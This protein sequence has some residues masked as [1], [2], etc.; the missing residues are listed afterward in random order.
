MYV[1]EN[2]SLGLDDVCELFNQ[3][4]FLIFRLQTILKI[5]MVDALDVKWGSY[6]KIADPV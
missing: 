1:I 6:F 4:D 2:Q 5:N 3:S